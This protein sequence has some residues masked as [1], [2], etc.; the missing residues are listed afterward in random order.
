ME[1]AQLPEEELFWRQQVRFFI[2]HHLERTVEDMQPCLFGV[3]MFKMR[4]VAARFS[5]VNNGPYQLVGEEIHEEV[6][7]RFVNHDN[8]T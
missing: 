8:R 2:E 1:P 4:S 7:V 6:F 5:L 3:G